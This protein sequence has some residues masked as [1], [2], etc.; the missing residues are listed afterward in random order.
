MQNNKATDMVINILTLDEAKALLGSQSAVAD[1]VG[2][3]DQHWSRW[4][5]K[6]KVLQRNDDFMLVDNDIAEF[7]SNDCR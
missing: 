2:K 7:L 5:G 4:I 1:A 3:L 6:K